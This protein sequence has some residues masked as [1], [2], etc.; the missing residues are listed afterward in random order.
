MKPDC[1]WKLPSGTTLTKS[2]WELVLFRDSGI[3]IRFPIKELEIQV[4][5]RNQAEQVLHFNALSIF[6][7]NANS[8]PHN[9]SLIQ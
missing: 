5:F 1:V 7:K 3:N 6:S 8:E 9:Q 2:R 4:S